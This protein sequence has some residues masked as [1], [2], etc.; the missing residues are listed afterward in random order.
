MNSLQLIK[1]LEESYSETN[2]LN[3][4]DIIS[5]LEEVI[6]EKGQLVIKFRYINLLLSILGDCINN[7]YLTSFF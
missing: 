5:Y 2:L 3:C 4:I 1:I 7:E 6:G